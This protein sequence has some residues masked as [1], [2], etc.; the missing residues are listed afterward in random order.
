MKDYTAE[1]LEKLSISVEDMIASLKLLPPKARLSISID[2]YYGSEEKYE[3]PY[4]PVRDGEYP[5]LYIIG[6]VE[7]RP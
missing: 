1:E 6:S 7:G 2:L 4:T 3:R 5:N